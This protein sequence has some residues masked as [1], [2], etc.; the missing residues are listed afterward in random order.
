MADYLGD[1]KHFD[2][3][4]LLQLELI[5]LESVDF[6]LGAPTC[7]TFLQMLYLERYNHMDGETFVI[8]RLL[9]EFGMWRGGRFTLQTPEHIANAALLAAR[10]LLHLPDIIFTS[11]LDVKTLAR[12]LVR[13]IRRIPRELLARHD[14]ERSYVFEP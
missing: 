4:V 7:E 10:Q 13:E 9:C 11:S 5:I 8:A 2:E 6:D 3:K 14:V 1:R 12:T